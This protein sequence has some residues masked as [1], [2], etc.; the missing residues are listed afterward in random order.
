MHVELMVWHSRILF[1]RLS[2]LNKCLIQNTSQHDPKV[3]EENSQTILQDKIQQDLNTEKTK[4]EKTKARRKSI[5]KRFQAT[6]HDTALD[7]R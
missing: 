7:T 2:L 5:F 1:I 4:L 6:K 3:S